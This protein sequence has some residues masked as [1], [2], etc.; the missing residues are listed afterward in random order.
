MRKYILNNVYEII[1]DQLQAM[2][3]EV[4]TNLS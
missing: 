2:E 1:F 3:L 4:G